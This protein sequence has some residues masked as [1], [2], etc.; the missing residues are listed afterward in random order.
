MAQYWKFFEI[1]HLG[2]FAAFF[3]CSGANRNS[4]RYFMWNI[5]VFSISFVI[6]PNLVLY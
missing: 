6:E 5:N 4:F 2:L 1:I 3:F